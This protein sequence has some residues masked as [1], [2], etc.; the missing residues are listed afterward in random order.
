VNKKVLLLLVLSAALLLGLA[1]CAGPTPETIVEKV[2][3]TVVVVETVEVVKEVEGETV[4]VVE[5]V[6]VVQEVEKEVVVTVEVE[7]V[8]EAELER[9]KTLI[10]DLEGGFINDPDNWSPYK[11]GRPGEQ[12]IVQLM[13]EPLF[14]VNMITGELD[15]YLAESA[16]PNE[17][18][19]V[20]TVAL[21]EGVKW[22]DGEDFTADD[23]VFTVEMIKAHPDLNTPVEWDGVTAT[24]VDDLTVEFTLEESD[25]RFQ[26]KN[27]VGEAGTRSFFVVPEHIWAEQED[28]VTFR[29]YDPDKGWPVF[30]GPYKI[31]SASESV[32][33]FVRDDNWW[34]AQT[35]FEDLPA[36]EKVVM[37]Y[38]GT[39]ET[40]AAAIAKND[41]DQ[42]SLP[43]PAAF[44]T[45]RIL[46]D[47]IVSWTSEPPYGWIDKCTRNLEFN[48]T[49]EPWDD[50]EMRWAINHAVD[51]DQIVDIAY[52]G[53]AAPSRFHMPKFPALERYVDLIDFDKYPVETYDPELTKSIL[54][55]KGYVMNESTGYYEKDGEELTVTIVNF[56][57]TII[58]TLNG[59]VIEQ[60]QAVGINAV[61]DI[62][63]IPNFIDN[64]MNGNL[65]MYIFF[66]SCGSKLDPWISLDAYSTRHLPAE[67][68][69][70]D[71]FY[72]NSARWSGENAEKYSEIVAEIG[73][74]PPGDPKIEELFVEAQDYWFEDLPAVPLIQNP[75]I[76]P[77]SQAYW[78]NWPTA[79]NP[80][81]QPD[82]GWG[83][84]QV[85]IH[86]LEPA[87]E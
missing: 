30:T 19:T 82:Q 57:D 70:V 43:S 68:E 63:T 69:P 52:A 47:Q 79:D 72:S 51:R 77:F 21:R 6:E 2:V 8:D 26:E 54:E 5:T 29:N 60:L 44:E 32:V 1:A 71:G 86:N 87:K 10:L 25:P 55:S 75:I 35:G 73:A 66:G 3:E 74:L 14:V 81:I 53:M 85:V 7:K 80:Y 18:F 84:F 12:G 22:S 46:N 37:I 83:S 39:E 27:M 31:E 33:N 48:H 20:W 17:D 76:W 9:R 49:V 41:L 65:E 24:K 4:T 28:P 45:M 13:G 56:D 16:T 67:G 62:Q 40:R 36:P 50:P 58:N 59:V 34:G 11:S 38:Y 61:Q 23:I 64:L 78:T 42:M 15:P